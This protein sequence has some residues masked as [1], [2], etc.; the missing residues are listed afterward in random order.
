M[1]QEFY[2]S[3]DSF[4]SDVLKLQNKKPQGVLNFYL[5]EVEDDLEINLFQAS[6]SMTSFVLKIQHFE[7]PIDTLRD[8]MI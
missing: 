4:H 2:S 7:F 8:T 5:S 6:N 1:F 3:I